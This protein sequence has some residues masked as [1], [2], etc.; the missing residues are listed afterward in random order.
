MKA[1]ANTEAS[2]ALP[3]DGTAEAHFSH[4]AT[5]L[6]DRALACAA[7]LR[8]NPDAEVLHDLR[9]S[10]RRL[11]SLLWAY[12]PLLDDTFDAQQRA[13]FKFFASAAGKT[14][15]WDILIGLLEETADT[16]GQPHEA[17]EAARAKA[18]D[19][20][21]ETLAHANVKSALR[22]AL[23]DA[24]RKLNTAHERT[25]LPK[26]ARKRLTSAQRSMEKR[27][28]RASHA[29][30]SDYAS[31]HEVR[32]AGK[33]LRYLIEFFEPVLKKKQVKSVSSLK[34][35]QKRF[36]E[37]NDVIASEQLLRENPSV[38]SDEALSARALDSL[39]KERKRR[40]RAAARLL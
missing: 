20:S 38:F 15:D 24:N 36:G 40:M 39:A 21:R 13:L 1:E 34:K 29:K 4:Y 8:A 12:R 19:A 22:D 17:L 2:H 33:K 5:P 3:H 25:P 14:R 37:L 35:L 16:Q 9:V 32:K 10:L 28:K 6:I 31:Y 26:F 7:T 23:K 11:R 18:L 27:M 30:R